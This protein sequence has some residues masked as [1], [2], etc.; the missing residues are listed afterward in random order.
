MR[1]GRRDTDSASDSSTV[2][3]VVTSVRSCSPC[4]GT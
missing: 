2:W 1:L 4:P 3:D